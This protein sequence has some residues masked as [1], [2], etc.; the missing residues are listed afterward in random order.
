MN[1]RLLLALAGLALG[2][3]APALAQQ[4]ETA[5]S[6]IVQQLEA[7]GKKNDE[8]FNQKDAAAEAAL[9]TDNAVFVTPSGLVYGRQVIEKWFADVFQRWHHSNQLTKGDQT[10]PP[11]VSASGNEALWV[12][13]WSNT[14]QTQ[15]DQ[16]DV[17]GYWSA[18]YIRQGDAW[19]IRMLTYNVNTTPLPTTSSATPSPTATPS[20]Q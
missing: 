7:I 20:S 14:V 4:K 12:G 2:F 3:T 18:V 9:F 10:S 8:A 6:Q 11:A 19:M 17:K 15:N 13:E 5:D 16:M 1:T